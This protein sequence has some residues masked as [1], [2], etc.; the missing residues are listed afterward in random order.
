MVLY[1]QGFDDQVDQFEILRKLGDGGSGQVYLV[2][3]R[4]TDEKF[5]LKKIEMKKQDERYA[6]QI[7]REIELQYRCRNSNNIVR[8]KEEFK[9]Q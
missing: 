5:A 1:A 3:H 9:R 8:F 4:S 2:H 6:N 7:A